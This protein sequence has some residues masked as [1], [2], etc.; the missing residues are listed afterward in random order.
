MTRDRIPR[1][2]KDLYARH[3]E[4]IARTLELRGLDFL[5]YGVL[6]FLI[7]KIALPGRHGEALYTLEEL[8]RALSWP[9]KLEPLRRRLHGLRN[10]GWIEFENPRRGPEAP[11]IFRLSGAEVDAE[12]DES[13]VSFD[14]SFHPERALREETV[15]TQA[16]EAKGANQEPKRVS[17]SSEFPPRARVEQSRAK[18]E[19]ENRGSEETKLDHVLGK[20]TPGETDPAITDR[21]I[22]LAKGERPEIVPEPR[23]VGETGFLAYL[24]ALVDAGIGEWIE[25]DAEGEP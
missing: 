21:L 18:S 9:L 4:R 1:A 20:T 23:L 13:L 22:A 15:S 16:Q 11:W 14:P 12:R 10:A 19:I 7:D 6:S 17:E 24:Q 3:S 5:S 2:E 25:H 8:A